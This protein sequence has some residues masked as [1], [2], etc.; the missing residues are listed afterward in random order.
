MAPVCFRCLSQKFP[1]CFFLIPFFFSLFGDGGRA[2]WQFLGVC[3]FL[4]LAVSGLLPLL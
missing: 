2:I 4:S 3:F 1:F